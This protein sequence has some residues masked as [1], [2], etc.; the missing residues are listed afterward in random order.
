MTGPT[1]RVFFALWPSDDLRQE[2]EQATKV[3]VVQVKGRPIPPRNFHVT[4][5]FLGSI[6]A[7]RLGDL[8]RCKEET[9]V[10]AFDFYLDRI[11]YWKRQRLLCL[12]PTAGVEKLG[13]L[14]ER[15]RSALAD[16]HFTVEQR[17]FRAH[18]TLAREVFPEPF[19]DSITELRLSGRTHIPWHIP[20]PIPRPIRW[21][22]SRLE[23]IESVGNGA[24]NYTVL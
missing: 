11:S 21:P 5:A 9:T 4:L 8:H 14:I 22:V 18:V 15:L 13:E 19:Q 10:D 20:W 3:T 6:A 16:R 12:E 7:S 17:P 23:L 2:I 24:S 1:R